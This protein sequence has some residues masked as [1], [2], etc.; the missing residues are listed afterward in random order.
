MGGLMKEFLESVVGEGFDPNRGLFSATPDGCAY[1]NPLAG[2]EAGLPDHLP[3]DVVRAGSR[4][5]PQEERPV[6]A[7]QGQVFR[8]GSLAACRHGPE[9]TLERATRGRLVPPPPPPPTPTAERLDGGPAA[10]ETLGLVL[11]RALYEGL[12]LDLPLAPFFVSRLQARR[13]SLPRSPPWIPCP[14]CQRPVAG[15]CAA[16]LISA[17]LRKGTSRALLLSD[18]IDFLAVS[19]QGRWPLFDELQ[20]LDPEVY[21][22]LMQIKRYDGDVADLCL[23]FSGQLGGCAARRGAAVRPHGFCVTCG[24]RCATC[25]GCCP[26]A[27]VYT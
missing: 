5:R 24:G 15:A 21:R 6:Q 2:A 19:L 20:A 22:S 17:G 27:W 18:P 12:L 8:P 1:P 16:A 7:R 3:R 10:L 23:D 13:A 11:G 14:C 4:A 26:P 9:C 25:Q